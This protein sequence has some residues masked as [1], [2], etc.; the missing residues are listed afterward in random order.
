[1]KEEKIKLG[2]VGVDSGQL[3]I[4]DPGYIDSEWKKEEFIQNKEGNIK[5]KHPFSYNAAC[6]K[7]IEGLGGQL[8]FKMGHAGVGV[9]FSSGF[10]DGVYDV[11]AT[12]SDEGKSGKIVKKVEIILI[13]K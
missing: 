2:V 3:I 7:T 1:M 4:C 12:I 10:G 9:A 11:I 6:S 5:P 8:N 13:R